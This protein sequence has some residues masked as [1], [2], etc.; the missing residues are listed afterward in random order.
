MG[1]W[2]DLLRAVMLGGPLNVI[3]LPSDELHFCSAPHPPRLPT[4]H[5]IVTS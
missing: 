3:V 4:P 5:P 1:R 2:L